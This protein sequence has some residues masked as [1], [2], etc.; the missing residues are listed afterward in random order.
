MSNLKK[1]V[2][3]TVA[4]YIIYVI[5]ISQPTK[6]LGSFDVIRSS[7][8]INQ[9]LL[10]ELVKTEGFSR[11]AQNQIISFIVKDKNGAFATV[12]LKKPVP[13]EIT[14]AKVVELFGHMHQDTFVATSVTIVKDD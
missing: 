5:I 7:G 2:I 11:N 13:E 12:Q 10:A 3:P 1:I 9:T 4:L 8:E 14:Y 6:E